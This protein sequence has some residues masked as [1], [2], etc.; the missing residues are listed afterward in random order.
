MRIHQVATKSLRAQAASEPA[1]SSGPRPTPNI[2]SQA[3]LPQTRKQAQEQPQWDHASTL[4]NFF[5]PEGYGDLQTN[6]ASGTKLEDLGKPPAATFLPNTFTPINANNRWSAP[7]LPPKT[8]DDQRDGL[9]A[10]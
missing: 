10:I 6:A 9:A 8:T 5:K 2:I 7:R 4:R 3:H 1:S